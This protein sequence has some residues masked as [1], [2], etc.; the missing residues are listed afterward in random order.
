VRI[1]TH[2]NIIVRVPADQRYRQ[3]F[4]NFG[5]WWCVIEWV[6]PNIPESWCLQ[7]VMNHSHSTQ[8]HVVTSQNIRTPRTYKLPEHTN[9]QNIWT[10][11]I[12]A[13][14]SSSLANK[15]HG[16]NN[17]RN[18]VH[19]ERWNLCNSSRRVRWACCLL[20]AVKAV[21]H[22]KMD[23]ILSI[24]GNSSYLFF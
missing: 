23:I 11:S 13:V 19:A 9:S 3:G 24:L 20:P 2:S 14:K 21:Q 18:T 4:K 22:Y 12:T 15:P 7:N 6:D 8:Q 10:L 1:T 16:W 17:I 5:M